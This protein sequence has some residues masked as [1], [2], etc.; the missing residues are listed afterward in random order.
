M[1]S[2]AM[3]NKKYE[4]D[5]MDVELVKQALRELIN[6]QLRDFGWFSFKAMIVLAGTAL[7]YFTLSMTGWVHK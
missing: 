2:W 7:L 1:G 5:E 3:I 4:K 6:E